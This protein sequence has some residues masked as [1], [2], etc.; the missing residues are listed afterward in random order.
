MIQLPDGARVTGQTTFKRGDGTAGTVADAT[1]DAE[2][3]SLKSQET[4]GHGSD[5]QEARCR[6]HAEARFYEVV[7]V[8][9]AIITGGGDFMKRPG[10]QA[11]LMY[12]DAQPGES[13]VIV[14][15]DLKRMSRDTRAVLDLRDAFRLRCV[16]IESPNFSFE[17]TPEGE[18]AKT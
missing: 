17:D 14:F 1:L 10:M 15:D 12:I 11:L 4:D 2:T 7:S 5:S 8:F 3:M 9:P 6:A 13:L 18:F 16:H